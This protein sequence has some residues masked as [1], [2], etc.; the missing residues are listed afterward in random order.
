MRK[1]RVHYTHKIATTN[2]HCGHGK[3]SHHDLSERGRGPCPMPGCDC[4]D[5][6]PGEHDD[7]AKELP[8]SV[9]TTGTDRDVAAM[10]REAKILGRG[11]RLDYMRREGDRLLCFPRAGTMHCVAIEPWVDQTDGRDVAVADV[12]HE[13]AVGHGERW[14]AIRYRIRWTSSGR[15]YVNGT[16]NGGLCAAYVDGRW[17]D[18]VSMPTSLIV[19]VESARPTTPVNAT[20]SEP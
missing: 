13:V 8:S 19:A 4:L 2:C 12:L 15:C 10:L 17:S 6:E 3:Y 1:Y 7:V 16:V 14:P 5:Y 18:G 9:V 20:R 11:E